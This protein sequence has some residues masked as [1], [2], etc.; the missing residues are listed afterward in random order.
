MILHQTPVN[1]CEQMYQCT[2]LLMLI[3]Q[4][5]LHTAPIMHQILMAMQLPSI[6]QLKSWVHSTL[7]NLALAQKDA[8][9]ERDQ[10]IHESK[11][12]WGPHQ[13]Q[14]HY[15]NS[16]TASNSIPNQAAQL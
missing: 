13:T 15:P 10:Q 3:D 5:H 11:Q 4:Q 6:H 7:P 16:Q 8:Q 2:T 1:H 9:I 14:Y 12:G